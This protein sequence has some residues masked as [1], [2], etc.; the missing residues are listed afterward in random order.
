MIIEDDLR[1]KVSD[2]QKRTKDTLTGLIG[3]NFTT[4]KRDEVVATMPVDDRTKQPFGILHGGAS[5]ALAEALASIGAWLNVDESKF[6]VVGLEINAN[7]I[8]AVTSGTVIGTATPLH[9]GRTTHVWE[10]KIRTEDGKLVCASRC[11]LAV[12]AKA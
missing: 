5:V 2:L 1:A 12:V 10:V 7:H 4:Y 9:R 6:N 8:R 3:M 11:T